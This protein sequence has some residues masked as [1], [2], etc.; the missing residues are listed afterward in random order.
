LERFIRDLGCEHDLLRAEEAFFKKE[1][2]DT[3]VLSRILSILK[4]CRDEPTLLIFDSVDQGGEFL[5]GSTRIA[6]P[7]IPKYRMVAHHRL[8]S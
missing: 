2:S 6:L 3:E 4:K 1:L 8:W 7:E 5:T